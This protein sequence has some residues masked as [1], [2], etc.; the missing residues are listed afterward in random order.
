MPSLCAFFD[1]DPSFHSGLP[2]SKQRQFQSLRCTMISVM[3]INNLAASSLISNRSQT[4]LRILNV[5]LDVL[6]AAARGTGLI[7]ATGFAT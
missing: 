6:A 3:V 1:D 5:R 2:S 4:C 7:V